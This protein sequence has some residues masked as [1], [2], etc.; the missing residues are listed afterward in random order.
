MSEE[1]PWGLGYCKSDSNTKIN[2][3]NYYLFA[4]NVLNELLLHKTKVI[5]DKF[6]EGCCN[7][8][9]WCNINN[10]SEELKQLQINL[11]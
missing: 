8:E 7:K 3:F 10:V 4:K 2:W 5:W 9:V 11:L 1:R 6:G